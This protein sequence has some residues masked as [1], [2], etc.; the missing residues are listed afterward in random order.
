MGKLR[1]LLKGPDVGLDGGAVALLGEGAVALPTQ[2]L[3]QPPVH[4]RQGL[5]LP[6]FPG[7]YGGLEMFYTCMLCMY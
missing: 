1:H 4:C 3:T 7:I 5:S 2:I 6:N